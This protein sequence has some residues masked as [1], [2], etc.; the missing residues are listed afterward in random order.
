MNDIV[1]QLGNSAQKRIE[2]IEL[3]VSSDESVK[4]AARSLARQQPLYGII[5]SK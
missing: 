5:R 1:Q 4:N 3:D 2:S